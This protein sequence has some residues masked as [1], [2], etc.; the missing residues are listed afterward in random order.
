M[1]HF[2]PLTAYFTIMHIGLY[3]VSIEM[4][5][6]IAKGHNALSQNF[7]FFLSI[8]FFLYEMIRVK[9]AESTTNKLKRF[10]KSQA[11]NHKIR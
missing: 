10:V 5:K 7:I 3:A 1:S 11:L 6:T 8:L 4:Y 2:Y 9:Q